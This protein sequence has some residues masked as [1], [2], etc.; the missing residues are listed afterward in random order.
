MSRERQDDL[1]Q[2]EF[3]DEEDTLPGAEPALALAEAAPGALKAGIEVIQQ[4]AKHLPNRPGVYRMFDRAG[5]VLYVGKAKSLKNR[6]TSYAR[7]MA[8]T[9]AVARMIAETA[10]ME[11][12]TTGTET[13][14][15]LLESNLIKQLRPRYN[16]LLRDDKSFPYI[17]LTGDHDA[18]A[19]LKHRGSRQRKGDYFG[20]FASVWAV[21]RTIDALQKAFLI[22][23]CADSF[24]E[25]RTRPCLLFQIKRCA[26]P[27]TGE[28]SIP[29]YQALAGQ[30]RDFL[31]GRSSTV[32]QLLSARMQEAAEEL[33]FE[34]AARYRDRLAALSAVQAGQ[35]INTQGVEEA[36]VFA[37]DEQAGQFCVEIFF[38]RNHQ[39]WGNRALFPRADRSL[40][41]AEVLASV[42]AQFYDDKPPPRLVLLSH[43]VEEIELIGQALSAR[44]GRKV[45]VAHPKRGERADLMA[46]AVKNARE[47][48]SRKLA[49]NAGQSA[50][51]AALGAA[52]GME[53]AP[54]R[55]EVYDNS[56]IMGTNAVGG[57]IVAGSDGFMKNQYRTFNI[58]TETIAG[59]DFGMMREVLTRR[60]A[61]LAKESGIALDPITEEHPPADDETGAII[62]QD[63][64][65]RAMKDEA[66]R[67]KPRKAA[68]PR[69]DEDGF[70]SRPDLVIVDGGKGQFTAA[71]KI[72]KD[73]G[74]ADIPLVAIAKGEDRNAM[75]ETFHME[76]K[77]PFKLQPRDPA[78]YFIQRLRDE[79]HR[80]AIG[81]H[82]AKR[83][84]E[85]MK[86]PL[87]EIPGI[88]PSRKR[89][90]LL[91]FGTVKAIQRAKLDD[92]MR[93]PGVNAATAK[94]VHDF[95]HD[96]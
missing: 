77:E 46:H 13:E 74:A 31:S 91:H 11:F 88:G 93:T 49:D 80:F 85:T 45:E 24:Y 39:N 35:D 59:D 44:A 78:L 34:K 16:V 8:H 64:P 53:A 7:G 66:P 62:L 63:A 22:R 37:I 3:E 1:P 14:A 26:G 2:D 18:P 87:D 27:C 9:N 81:T 19:I 12:V 72:M 73:L 38:F 82:R 43:P 56:H 28:I 61:K 51:L 60:F 54:R 58:S 71:L 47:A 25:N 40:T 65:D 32:K 57:M 55:V 21:T 70:P 29:E 84:R 15:L 41:P 89:A 68:K 5:E 76:G 6:V 96:A 50:L 83:K 4:F 36:D 92:L 90:L 94:A 69:K 75:R 10:N 42:V 20:P 30:A 33:E 48:L 17:L 86:N 23:T 95:F 67:K 79:A 52:F